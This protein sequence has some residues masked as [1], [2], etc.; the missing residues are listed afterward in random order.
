[1]LF[2]SLEKKCDIQL[3]FPVFRSAH[4]ALLNQAIQAGTR[5]MLFSLAPETGVSIPRGSSAGSQYLLYLELIHL[6]VKWD[7]AWVKSCLMLFE[8]DWV[9]A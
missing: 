4:I 6:Y 3:S 8:V 7:H 2:P 9:F 5:W 1:M